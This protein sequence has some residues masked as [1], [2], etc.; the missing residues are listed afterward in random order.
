VNLRCVKCGNSF[1]LPPAETLA[2]D[3]TVSCPQ[4]GARY[5]RGARPTVSSAPPPPAPA[6][7][8]A[9]NPPAVRTTPIAQQRRVATPVFEAGDL[10]GGRYRVRA[11]L[12]QGGMGEVYEAEDQELRVE[13][14]LKTIRPRDSE[15][16]VALERLKREI[17]LARRVTHPNVCRIFD[18]GYHV[19]GQR[20][21]A[22]LTMELLRGETLAARL[23]RAGRFEPPAALPIV[24]QI[25]AA[26]DAA[27]RA[28]VIHRDFK[29][30]NVF[31]VPDESEEGGVRAVV[32]DF[33]IARAGQQEAMRLTQ[34]GGV[35]GTPAY[36]A[37]E[38]LEGREVTAAADL[39]AFGLVIYE[40]VTGQLPFMGD[41]AISTAVRR[42]TEAPTSPRTF[43]PDLD[44]RWEAM[45]LRCLARQ[46]EERFATASEAIAALAADQPVALPPS[47][48]SAVPPRVTPAPEAPLPPEAPP[49]PAPAGRRQRR[50][51]ILL[52]ALL[53]VAITSAVVRIRALR[54]DDLVPIAPRRSVAVLGFRNVAGREDAAWLSTALGEMLSTELSAGEGLR[55]VPG[56]NVARARIELGGLGLNDNDTLSR[57]TLDKLRAL[58]GADYV[59]LGSY[60]ALGPQAGGRL[61]LDVRLQ[62]A[63]A[64]VTVASLGEA[65]TEAELFDLVQKVGGSLRDRLGLKPPRG[66]SFWDRFSPEAARLYSEGVVKLRSFEPLQA[67]DLLERAVAADPKSPLAHAALAEA[68]TTLGYGERALEESRQAYELSSELE[69]EVRLSIEGRYREALRDWP[70]AAEIYGELVRL[71]PDSL[72]YGLRLAGAQTA[73]AQGKAALTTIAILRRLPAPANEDPRIDL[74]ASTAAASLADYKL[75]QETAARAAEGGVR[76]GARLLVAQARVAEGWASR[77]LGDPD[78]AERVCAEAQRIF[79]D[80]G[81]RAGEAGALSTLAGALYDRGDLAG[82]IE[83]YTQALQIYRRVGDLSGVA[84][85]LNNTAVVLKNQGDPGRARAMYEETLSVSR[86]AGDRLG[87]AA[88]LNNVGAVLSQEGDLAA[89]KRK[90]EESLE[91]R[92]QLGDPSGIAYAISNIAVV[93][94]KQGAL[95]EARTQQEEALRLRRETGQKIGEMA[96]LY[97]LGRVLFDQADLV[98]ARQR[99]QAALGGCREIANKSCTASALAGM[100]ELTASSDDLVGARREGEEALRLREEMGERTAAAETRSW[101]GWLRREEGDPAAAAREL[102]VARDLLRAQRAPDAEAVAGAWLAR[103]L[104]ETHDV[105]GARQALADAVALAERSQ[106]PEAR[107][108]VDIAAGRVAAAGGDPQT[109]GGRLRAAEAEA[110]RL[111]LVELAFEARLAAAECGVLE[112]GRPAART[113]AQE[114]QARG[115]GAISRQA[116]ALA[117]K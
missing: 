60:T 73:A 38:Q 91:I 17:Q 45:I 46:P 72:D 108:A 110:R 51:A 34:T 68:W 86:E 1:A 61:R 54:E 56:E 97:L 106:S 88:A 40:M 57:E 25:G 52:V 10:I 84:R 71:Y 36:M 19:A 41:T 44:G 75:Q 63:T 116:A 28:G 7:A 115:L 70:K 109:A 20:R 76:S 18:V 3:A 29:S 53:A 8:P 102:R 103:A 6:E 31:L 21:I 89:A 43:V 117:A 105:A 39:Y 15:D 26:L 83:R 98:A 112:G 27:H 64:G 92:R 24:R 12:A 66:A 82:A 104:V 65:G 111:G 37:P 96:S 58:L 77:N 80:A 85:V 55:A 5:R 90:L 62:D 107:L 47:A 13:V 35:I 87:E 11:F 4:C 9:E 2:P 69:P 93:Q 94:H 49:S 42:L 114:A 101:L 95:A 30:E 78:R 99:F 16:D 74:A 33:G 22:F 32:A 81:D 48:P 14:A 59:V 100:T 113:L 67:R 79:A 50:L 23:Q